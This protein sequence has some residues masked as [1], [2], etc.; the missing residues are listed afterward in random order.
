MP[1]ID[2][3]G[4]NRMM[5]RV[6]IR[7]LAGQDQALIDRVTQQKVS[8]FHIVRP[9]VAAPGKNVVAEPVQA[10]E[11]KRALDVFKRKHK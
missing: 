1:P 10:D 2:P 3:Y 11:R 5:G 4:G 6:R 9:V 7:D 8:R